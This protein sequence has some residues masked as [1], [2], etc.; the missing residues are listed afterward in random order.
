M[1]AFFVRFRG[2]LLVAALTAAPLVLLFAETR[3]KSQRGPAVSVLLDAAS[4]I[5]RPL[6]AAAGW[7]SDVLFSYVTGVSATGELATLRRRAAHTAQLEA[8]VVEL[9]AE[10]ER[11]RALSQMAARIDGARIVGARVIGRTGGPVARV[12]RI[13][14]GQAD[15]VR[16]GHGVLS[17]RGVV[18]RV[19]RAGQRTSDVLLLTDPGSAIDVVVQRSRAR[20]LVRG[21]T[22]SSAYRA[23][24]EDFDRLDDAM[25]GDVVV[26]NGLA[27][28]FLPG[29]LVGKL[30]DVQHDDDS[31]VY[32]RARVVPAVHF[33]ALEEVLV[34]VQGNAGQLRPLGGT[35][36]TLAAPNAPVAQPVPNPAAQPAPT[37]AAQPVPNPAAQ[38]A[39]KPSA[40]PAAQ[41]VESVP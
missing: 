10:N 34:L 15:G 5:E 22:D 18:G 16:R 12:L 39:P 8:T 19:L 29:L 2:P 36:M 30:E 7:V 17:S 9:R 31:G 4:V 41:P 32:A 1:L 26:T 28:S 25:D 40:Q 24:V 14:R 33:A 13:D 23:R 27:G 35:G 3:A 38:P 11:L 21:A 37:P 6:V 20:G